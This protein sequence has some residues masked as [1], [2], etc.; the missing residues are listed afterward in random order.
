LGTNEEL[1]GFMLDLEDIEI[2]LEELI[3]R[4]Q[5]I[6]SEI[7]YFKKDKVDEL[8]K[9]EKLIKKLLKLAKTIE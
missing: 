9:V 2:I 7:E 4:K 1:G 3:N 6:Y 8:A 5:R